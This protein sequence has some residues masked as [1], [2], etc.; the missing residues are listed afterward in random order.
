MRF[1]AAA[2]YAMVSLHEEICPYEFMIDDDE[3]K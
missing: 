1:S 3:Y 2:I